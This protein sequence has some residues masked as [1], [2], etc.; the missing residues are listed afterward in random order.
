MNPNITRYWRQHNMLNGVADDLSIYKYMPLNYVLSMVQHN[1]LTINR[2]S[3]WP[4]VYEN[5][6]LKQVYSLH[7]G[8]PIDVINQADGIFG[9]CWTYLPESD[10]MWRIYSPDKMTVRIKTT[11]EKLYDALYQ[12]D[13]NMA[14]TYVGIVRYEN[15]N[16]ID[17]YVKSLSPLSPNDFLKEV[18]KGAFVK[19]DEFNHEKEVRIVRI[20][21]S[22]K[23]ILSGPFLQ[24]P[25]P[26]DFID[27][28][29]IDPRAD[30]AIEAN[31]SSQLTALG[32][33][34]GKI[35]KS[36]LYQFNANNLKFSM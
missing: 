27:E 21:D 29:C 1:L 8:T 24:F 31:I 30:S 35:T 25:I 7:D 33:P 3:S 17:N 26:V 11:V 10:A 22:A 9:Q 32:V 20:L 12:T 34:N 14:D 6:I 4:D 16:N 19:R 23:T 15:Q 13:H 2:I 5:F 36:H 28:F 18:V